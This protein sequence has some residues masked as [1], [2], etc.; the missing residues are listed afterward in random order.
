M[1]TQGCVPWDAQCLR[2]GAALNCRRSLLVV[3]VGGGFRSREVDGTTRHDRGN[4]VL[5]HHLRHGIAQQHDVLIEG[6]DLTLQLDAVHQIDRNRH[7]LPTQ[8]V[9]EG[10]LKKLTF[11]AHDILRVQ[12]CCCKPAPYH[13]QTAICRPG[14]QEF[15]LSV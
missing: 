1:G 2:R 4:G 13:S 9:Q 3:P 8:G 12:K 7:M 6:F 15:C 10:V 5:V 14:A 11:I